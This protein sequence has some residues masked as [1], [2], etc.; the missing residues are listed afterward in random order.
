MTPRTTTEP[1]DA[2]HLARVRAGDLEAYAH[3]YRRHVSAAVGFA[4]ALAGPSRAEDLTAEAF[5]RVLAVLGRGGGPELSFR[6]YLFTAIRNAHI[7]VA[8]KDARVLVVDDLGDLEPAPPAT[9]AWAEEVEN[10]LVAAALGTLPHRWQE[11]LRLTTVEDRPLGQV[12][13]ILGASPGAVAQLAYR[14]REA[15]RLAYLAQHAT[16]PRT[17]DCRTT[18]PLL[19]RQ[20]RSS[21]QTGQ[22]RVESHLGSCAPCRSARTE[23]SAVAGTLHPRGGS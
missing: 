4:S 20:A 14:A 17:E 19:A 3:L 2:D 18:I 15:L 1:T 16:E 6:A 22:R 8:R 13:E 10:R 5:A 21:G 11:V 23:I 7:N 9:D 12:A